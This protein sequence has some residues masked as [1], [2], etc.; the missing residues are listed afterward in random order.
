[1]KINLLSVNPEED[2]K[3]KKQKQKKYKLEEF[4]ILSLLGYGTFGSVLLVTHPSTKTPFALKVVKKALINTYKVN[5]QKEHIN[6]EKEVLNLVSEID[7]SFYVRLYETMQDTKGLYFLLE[8][9]HGGE[10]STFLKSRLTLESEG[11]KFYLAEV[12]VAL[13]QLHEMGVVYRD[14]KPENIIID[15]TGHIKL[16]DFGFAKVLQEGEQTFTN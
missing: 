9:I 2:L 3:A 15:K 12:I 10:L 16:V 7:N 5:K 14:L 1:M 13:E 6:N 11:I 4:T 8:Y